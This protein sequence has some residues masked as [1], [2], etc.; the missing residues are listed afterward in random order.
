MSLIL[1]P[2][3]RVTVDE[4]VRRHP[5]LHFIVSA[6]GTI[7]EYY[8]APDADLYVPVEAFLGKTLHDVLPAPAAS[9]IAEGLSRVRDTSLPVVAQY[10]LPMFGEE[11]VYE[12]R[13]IPLGGDGILA[14]CRDV[15][16]TFRAQER[17]R[18][19]EGRLAEA[20]RVGGIGTWLWES[21]TSRFSWS[22]GC[23]RIFGLAVDE[24]DE[25]FDGFL[26]RVHPDDV[27]H[28]REAGRKART[29]RRPIQYECRIV[30]PNLE[31]RYIAGS[32]HASVDADG[33]VS[34]LFGTAVD[35]TER[36][37]TEAHLTETLSLLQSTLDATTDG[38]LVVDGNR[39]I[40]SFNQRFVEMWHLPSEIVESRDDERA[41]ASVL[42]Q[43]S[44]PA[45]FLTKV[46]EMYD[47]SDSESFDVLEF[48]DGRTFE[49]YSRPHMIAGQWTGRVWSF[50]DVTS[51]RRAAA[52]VHDSERRFRQIAEAIDQVIWLADAETGRVLYVSPAFESI[53]GRPS[54]ELYANPHLCH[55]TILDSDRA[56]VVALQESW[57]RE[58]P[59]A[60]LTVSYPIE[61]P[62]GA[63]RWVL[64]T[65]TP[66]R[67]D[68]GTL[69]RLGGIAKDITTERQAELTRRR[70]ET[71]L[72]QAHKM[73][74]IGTLAAGIAHNFSNA[75]TVIIA[76]AQLAG[77]T[78]IDNRQALEECLDMVKGASA[79]AQTL[80]QQLAIFA[81]QS[82]TVLRPENL[83]PV[84]EAAVDTIR[85]TLPPLVQL[86]VRVE[87]DTPSVLAD[88]TQI[89]QVV[90]NLVTNAAQA[91]QGSAGRIEVVLER[92]DAT[93]EFVQAELEFV[94]GPYARLTVSDGGSGMEDTTKRHLFEPFFTTGEPATTSGLGLSVVHGVIKRH[95]GAIRVW[96]E[97]R[98]GTRL[99][100]YFPVR[101]VPLSH[102]VPTRVSLDVAELVTLRFHP[103]LMLTGAAEVTEP[104]LDQVR[105]ALLRPVRELDCTKHVSLPSDGGTLIL[106]HVASL[107]SAQQISLLQWLDTHVGNS[108]VV[109]L[110]AEPLFL[111]LERG[112]FLDRLYYRLNIVHRQ[113]D[114][115]QGF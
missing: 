90:T 14:I 15:T 62:S 81:R 44:D 106:R 38:I 77:I 34:A 52:A 54:E 21:A 93:P 60:P 55:D 98:A 97:E 76:N 4:V 57:L 25:T 115:D 17:L 20:E 105:G 58:N 41:M 53:W 42:D 109:S 9:Q 110:A 32:T 63:I 71:Q 19:A 7:L 37:R 72:V 104:V 49:R 65:M 75:L 74:A 80:V 70:L 46:R 100:L 92:F 113:C 84:V 96:S 103:N 45:T 3:R 10:T 22:A 59:T 40:V 24:F 95:G 35:V 102:D 114:I 12:A 82:A 56:R 28:V 79:R 5:D 23:Y 87:P 61:Q 91:M 64:D 69:Y 73:E 112:A 99:D 68:D 51:Q 43:L 111:L 88:V 6:D 2:R 26:A 31:V 89:Q 36:R 85:P 107:D 101:D 48:R 13:L 83:G 27:A 67:R 47:S 50:R 108:Q 78:G 11:R 8:G 16:E 94:V 66:I 30:R 29:Q 1:P 39:R 33:S 86:S 18:I